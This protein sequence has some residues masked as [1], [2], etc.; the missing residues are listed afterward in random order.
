[1]GTFKRLLVL[2]VMAVTTISTY[3]ELPEM[4]VYKSPHCGCCEHWVSHLEKNGI[5]VTSYDTAHMSK[6]KS[7]LGIT[8]EL[9]SCHTGII[10]GYFI[11]G[12]V[13]ASD[14]KKLLASKLDINGLA[15]PGMPAGANVP[16]METRP[17]NDTYD[18]LSVGKNG[19]NIFSHY[20]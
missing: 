7:K 18:V 8:R 17:E 3:A 16:G 20:E 6:I 12:H 4:E 9:A 14:I 15:A 13:P 5:K 2:L 10:D 1:M 11:E 19:V